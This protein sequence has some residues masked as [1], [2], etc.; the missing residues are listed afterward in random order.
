MTTLTSS[1]VERANALPPLSVDI[2]IIIVDIDRPRW[3]EPTME[4]LTTYR[5]TDWPI[6]APRRHTTRPIAARRV[7]RLLALRHASARHG[8]RGDDRH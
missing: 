6:T 7:R 4:H 3:T 2:D 5:T 8:E 1:S